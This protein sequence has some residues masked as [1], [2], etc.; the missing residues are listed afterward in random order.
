MESRNVTE[1][2][3]WK[4][5]SW[6]WGVSLRTSLWEDACVLWWGTFRSW[7]SRNVVGKAGEFNLL[8]LLHTN[9]SQRKQA[10]EGK[11]PLEC[12]SITSLIDLIP[13][14]YDSLSRTAR[15]LH[16]LLMGS[17]LDSVR[18]TKESRNPPD[19]DGSR[20]EDQKEG[21]F[22]LRRDDG[23]LTLQISS[24]YW[25]FLLPCWRKNSRQ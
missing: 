11:V 13:S 10:F 20:L 19:G 9:Q 17:F 18:Q 25:N 7:N 3:M 15:I 24:S 4:L 22:R 16:S 14:Y 6:E 2:S 12:I 1:R 21:H 5:Q 23:K 8:C